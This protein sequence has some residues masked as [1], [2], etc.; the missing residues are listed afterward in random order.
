MTIV[1]LGLGS[2]I[3]DRVTNLRDAIAG[4]AERGVAFVGASS[5][6]ETPPMP[7]D[8]PWYYNGVVVAETALEPEALLDVAKEV[9]HLAGRRPNR[10][11]GPR[12]LDIDILFYG[13]ERVA[14][15][16]LTVPHPGIAERGFVLAPLAE[17]WQGEL[18]VL[19]ERAVDHLAR[20]DRRGL[21]RISAFPRP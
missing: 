15:D 11:W 5:L 20:V 2:N 14:T 17:A 7:A 8:Q 12:P 1:I 21:S 4:L 9:E 19:G 10:H 13:D 16:R 6:W 3:G 18:P